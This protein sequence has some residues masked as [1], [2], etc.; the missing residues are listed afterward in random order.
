MTTT[1]S[2]RAGDAPQGRSG[3]QQVLV[4]GRDP[5]GRPL[6]PLR[7]RLCP[8]LPDDGIRGWIG[9]LLIMAFAAV[10]RIWDLGRPAKFV[11]DETYY[12][13]DAFSLLKFG[14][15]HQFVDKANERILAGDL[16]VFDGPA[17][18]VHPPAGKWM[19]A[20]GEALF[21]MDPFGWRIAVA[22]M[23]A[24][25]ILVMARL[26]RRLTRSTLLGCVAAFL[27]SLDGLHL[28]ES[29]IALLDLPAMFWLLLAVAVLLI[30][31]DW[32]RRRFAD[33][34][35]PLGRVAA[36]TWGPTLLWRPWRLVAGLCFGVACATK[37][38]A[39]IALA[40][41]GLLTWAW[42]VGAR[43]AVGAAFARGANL[44]RLALD[45]AVAF[46]TVA[47]TAVVVY[48][49][50][51]S[52]WLASADGYD[53]TWGRD[54][55]AHG[56]SALLPDAIRSLWHYHAEIWYFH[57][58]L[59]DKHQYASSPLGWLV[60]ARPVSFDWTDN[61][62]G[63]GCGGTNRC[64]QEI[65]G[66]GTPVLWWMSVVALVACLVWWLA[67]RD[68]RFGIPVVGVAATWLPW[69]QYAN[70]PI[71]NFYAIIILPWMIIGLTLV[72]GK[73]LGPRDASPIRRMWGAAVLGGVV[74]L[75]VLNFA[76]IYP[77]LTGQTIP[78]DAWRQRMWFTSWV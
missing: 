2:E 55:P 69:F 73:V 43:R 74:L 6:P 3:G 76:Y 11:F 66:I 63:A 7:Q 30:D 56:L 60:V 34:A 26:V 28:V 8:P 67:A 78:Y 70:R 27:L 52:G 75:V 15:E 54:N 64:V 61:V 53:R 24:L 14:V 31:R 58:H 9:P 45:A 23:G 62:G 37:W 38:N 72:L 57:T 51:W 77:L 35:E 65:L 12:P 42:D 10:L 16:D 1:A 48:V 59:T 5:D 49:V 21:G 19:I 18:I 17:F 46:L 39:A 68:W 47:G 71:F 50:S 20:A 22:I 29:R 4:A 41:F 25:S 44:A 13:K 40:A 33:A 32:A 36:G